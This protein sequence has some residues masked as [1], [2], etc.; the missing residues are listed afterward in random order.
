MQMNRL[1]EIVYLLMERK[2]LT[3]KEFAERFEVS[4][5]TIYRDI[6]T[7]GE[8][9][10]PV[11][12]SRGTGGGIRLMDD[13]VLNKSYLSEQEQNNILA[14]LQ[15]LSAIR[16]PDVEPV[17]TKL[18]A[19]FGKDRA[20]WIDVDFSNWSGGPQEREKFIL[21]KDAILQSKVITFD[22][23]SAVSEKTERVVEPLKILFKGMGWYLYG[24]CRAKQDY[25][26]F[27]ITRIKNLVNTEEAFDRA[28]P[29]SVF[30]QTDSAYSAKVI[31]L[32]LK[33]DSALAYRVYDEF[34]Q[35][36]II[37]DG[38]GSF[39]VSTLFPE[40]EWLFGFILSFGSGAQV[41]EPP[42]IRRELAARVENILKL[43]R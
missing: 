37:K 27:K 8:A 7:L 4:P 6:D 17:L 18:A 16:V 2:S 14:S 3:A 22:Y 34:E 12:T 26:V 40:G 35:E 43:Y 39:T 31:P 38:D 5:R 29:G 10:I 41:L 20:S 28:I 42:E 36:N 19:L 9:G 30:E 13:F 33:I 32:K 11:Y 25:R 24:F 15:G 1:F 21:L 23:Y